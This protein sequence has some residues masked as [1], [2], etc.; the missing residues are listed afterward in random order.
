MTSSCCSLGGLAG[1]DVVFPS[2]GVGFWLWISRPFLQIASPCLMN[3]AL[4]SVAVA[5]L[6][7]LPPQPAATAQAHGG[8]E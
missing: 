2:E 3:S 6:S 8:G 7:P 5:V 4:V 1:I